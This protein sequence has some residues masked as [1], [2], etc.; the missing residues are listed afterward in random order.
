MPPPPNPPPGHTAPEDQPPQP[1]QDG[2]VDF[3]RRALRSLGGDTPVN[4]EMAV[5]IANQEL[6]LE[7]ARAEKQAT[8]DRFQSI[9]KRPTR[10]APKEFDGKLDS[11]F[12]A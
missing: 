4:R 6:E 1:K 5:F 9:V 12:R 11:D 7:K 8:L 3:F 10:K 2:Y